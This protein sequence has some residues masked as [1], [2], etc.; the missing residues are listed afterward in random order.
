MSSSDSSLY[1]G[2]EPLVAGQQSDADFTAFFRDVHGCEPFPWQQR[3]TT[4][5]LNR[6]AWP[7]VIDLPTGTGKT[8]V[9]DTAVFAMAMQPETTPRRVVFVIDRRIVVD[10]VYKRAWRIRER[11]EAADTPV[12]EC[13]RDRLRTLSDGEPL[14]VAALRGGIPIDGEWTHRPDQPW[15]LVSTV[16]QF[17][18]RLLFRG[19]GVTSGMR[20][21]HAGLAGN[22]CLVILDEVHLSVPF[23]QTLARISA[24]SSGPLPRRF[25]TVEMSAT[26]SDR[27]STPFA[28]DSDSDLD[29]CAELRRRVKADKRAKLVLVRNQEMIP[30][31]VRKIVA[32]IDKSIRGNEFRARSVGVVVNRVRT[33]RD[34]YVELE[35]AGYP[36]HLITGRMRP[37]DRVDALE[38]IGPA[39]D[40]DGD[41][42]EDR[43]TVVVA[44]QAIEVGADFSFDALVTECAAVDSLRQRFGR[45]DRRGTYA[46]R[47]GCPAQAWIIGPKSVVGSRKPD[48]IYGESVRAT[49]EELERRC[50]DDGRLD[51]GP[52]ALRDF[53]DNATAPRTSAPLL[54]RTHLDAWV[55]TRPEPMVQ[56][57]IDWFLHGIDRNRPADVSVLWRWDRSSEALRLVPPRHAECIQVPIGA[58]KSWLADGPE[59]DIADAGEVPEPEDSHTSAE[60][61]GKDWVRWTGFGEGAKDDVPIRNIRPGDVLIVD[62]ERGGLTAGTWDPSSKEPVE[63][64]GDAA[65]IESGRRATLRLDP[66][67]LRAVSPH[68]VSPPTPADEADTDAS[69]YSR[70]AE[71]LKA[72]VSDPTELPHWMRKALEKLGRDF[73]VNA[74]GIG[75]DNPDRSYYILTSRDPK[76][77]KPVVDAGTLDDSDEAG[78]FTATGVSLSRHLEGVGER[79]GRIAERLGLAREIVG[80]LRLAGRLHDLGKVDSRFQSQLVGG[81]PVELAMRHGEPLAKS[82]PGARRVAGYPAGMR[83]EIASVAMIESNADVLGLAHDEDLMLHL[84][85]THHGWGRP[86]PPIIEDPDPEA[87]SYAWDG[88][89]LTASSDLADG[90]L[91]LDMADRFWRLVER[92]GYHG[93]AWLEA[94]L[95]L[96]DHRQSAEESGQK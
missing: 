96:A 93:L 23:A 57:S 17:G 83:H 40:P 31:H 46:E 26:P 80:D 43:L 2:I 67:L 77:K 52:T 4:Q 88:H 56:P 30:A 21:I 65:Q 35:S 25:A 76:T 27:K 90:S 8:A 69:P 16:D 91:A 47:T 72:P 75:N 20:P 53:P 82:L 48:P 68:V 62:P 12:L 71:W 1:E 54:L 5:V 94:V 64:L 73:D 9:L 7:R 95:R 74:V 89:F 22:D 85:G 13:I 49:W 34:T 28:L 6:R 10:Q 58:V 18:S 87:L 63:D 33:A 14:G 42:R 36:T 81:D 61:H 3:L 92:Y 55:Q 45:L 70:V 79:A 15:V 39:V 24:L 44:T 84:V 19:Y 66:N 11:I 32:S 29:R 51:I 86:L 41:Q 50:E 59:V 38:R 78:S 37:L 60:S